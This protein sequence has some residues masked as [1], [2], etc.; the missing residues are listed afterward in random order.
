MKKFLFLLLAALSI[1]GL[2]AKLTITKTDAYNYKASWELTDW[3]ISS[4]NEF[5]YII[6]E[7]LG[8]PDEPGMPLLPFDECKIIVPQDGSV[9][10][11]ILSQKTEDL[12]LDKRI[13][14]VPE[15]GGNGDVSAYSYII[16]EQFYSSSMQP[17]L[18]P[19]PNERFR[20]I[21]FVPVR[22]NPFAYDGKNRLKV[23]TAIEFNV[24]INGDAAKGNPQPVDELT[25]LIAKQTLNPESAAVWQHSERERINYADFS[26]SDFWVRVDTDK[27]GMFRLT[28]SQLSMLP[29]G[30]IDPRSFRLFTTGGEV[31]STLVANNGPVF[32]EVPIFVFGESDG[33]FNTNDYILFYGRDRDG[34]EM[35]QNVSSNQYNNPYSKNV[36]YWLTFGG[37]FSGDPLRIVQ[38]APIND[39]M[40][41]LSTT[42]ETVR[43]ENE[44][45]QRRPIGFDWYTGKLFGSTS[46]EYSYNIDLEDVETAFPQTLSLLMVQEYLKFSDAIHRMKLK[47]NGNQLTYTQNNSVS[48]TWTWTGLNTLTVNQATNF[49]TSGTNNL[50]V[51][52]LRTRAD[53][54]Y[55]DYYQVAYQKR[56][57]KRNKQFMVSIADT[58]FNLNSRYAFNGSNTNLRVFR[59]NI[60]SS[61][62]SVTEL[63]VNVTSGGFDFTGNG[64]STV[65]YWVVQDADYYT[66]AAIQRVQPVNLIAETQ[67]YD[68]LIITPPDYL[69]QA[70]SLATFYGQNFNKRSKVVLMQ[71]IFNQF[72]AGM[73]DPN[74]I[75]LYLKYCV[76][77]YPSPAITSVTLLGS[78]TI[79]WRN[80][81]G[82]AAVKNKVIVYQKSLSASDD[83]FGMLTTTAYPQIA[84]GRYPVRNQNELDIML[85]NLDKY[86]NE[87]QPG[88]WKNSLVFLADDQYNGPSQFEFDHSEQLQSTTEMLNKSI[89]VDKIFAIDYEFD[90]FQN[91]PKARDDMMSSINAGRLVWYYIGH[92]SFDTLGAED[93]FKGALDMGRFD[94]AGKLPLF[95][96]A[97][98][99]IAQFDSFAFDCLAEKVVMLNNKGAIAAIAATRECY[100]D[101]NVSLLKQYY[102]FSLN[103]R[104]PIG[105]SL[106]N[107]KFAYTNTSNNDKYNILGDPLLLITTPERDS[108]ITV[109]TADRDGIFNAREQISIAGQFSGQN[110]AGTSD[111]Y[112]Y[113]T[114]VRKTMPNNSLYT[115]RGK[116]VFRGTSSVD[117][118]RYS[119]GFIVPD[120]ITT[121]NSGLILAY[122][123]D[124]AA[125]KS[126]VNFM[127]S[128]SFSDEA[129]PVENTDAPLIELFLDSTGFE[130]GDTVGS[131]PL[132]IARISDSNGINLT[133]SPGH[134]MLLV[135]DY[136]V[137]T[138]N[139]TS[140]FTY[141]K[142]S[143]T[144]GTLNYQITGLS[145]GDHVLQLIAFDSFNRPSVATI[146][147]R[148]SKS[149]SFTIEDFLPYPNPMKRSG[150]FTFKASDASDVT[151][152][153]YT[154]RGR[155]IR[156][157][158]ATAVRGYNQVAWD[159]RDADGD[160]LANNTYFIKITAKP[161]TGSGKAEKTE[162]LVIYN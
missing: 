136:T 158:K 86:V 94:N 113:D 117:L 142:D 31:H 1:A 103:Q 54:L 146:S 16:N 140:Y 160:Y 35:N 13:R 8:F 97:S 62:Y 41:T 53:N 14:P 5:S 126:Y 42:P 89:L 85:S 60:S 100:G 116:S 66:P 80:Y 114:E 34:F 123:W 130:D 154:V 122:L 25:A 118:S 57:I 55:F 38:D 124:N 82:Q 9:S 134:S 148:V 15:I 139:V 65:K 20:R 68:N 45:Y 46:A 6:A 141:D 151:I 125:S 161:L 51:N 144:Q 111:V 121:G 12:L 83:Y 108:T 101:A 131:N 96:A 10:I 2:S 23:T 78:G 48:D 81:S 159:G 74:A 110:L 19:L 58:L 56:L 33:V 149:K 24:S 72:N 145:E 37:S 43:I 98:C 75:R 40:H 79:D 50:I 87:P 7:D 73:P 102:R 30:D 18:N 3:R 70:Q 150:W 90:E 92:G 152:S 129:V 104:N 147:F 95:I 120:D 132:L 63:P 21:S 91:K 28:P 153:I 99:D 119:S 137:S 138:T 115:L 32:R 155:K 133:N 44:S 128:V 64:N 156:T 36:S 88:I 127:P 77:N 71:D 52:I 135:L 69:Q 112:V 29:V 162:K 49:F 76:N 107:A 59:A 106:L 47:V 109:Q 22:I 105:Y 157:I 26:L 27:D 4:N 143:F 93:Y 39:F 61:L 17:I 84:I 11:S 67:S